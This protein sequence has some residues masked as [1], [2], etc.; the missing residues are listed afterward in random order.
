MRVVAYLR[1]S[2]DE[3]ASSGAGIEA[4]RA[5]ILAEAKRRGWQEAD[6]EFIEDLGFSAKNINRPGL[7]LALEALKRG[8]AKALVVA[9]MDRLS[10]SLLDFTQIMAEAQKQ[11][12]CL[13]ALDS[14]A[15]PSTPT[16]EAMISIL[17]TLA[18]WERRVIGLR[19]REALAI[20]RK[21]GVRLGR[22][23]TLPDQVRKRIKRERAKQRSL[24]AIA[25]ALN[26][27]RVPTAHGGARWHASTVRAVLA[28]S[29]SLS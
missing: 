20:K 28:G 29:R 1:V 17:A 25:A 18:Q 5:A 4:Q 23:R 10:R 9:K 11:G 15:D 16:G 13:I 19:T 3:Q 27:D 24:G 22:P 8:D 26:A 14:P 6:I 21:E 12:W 7:Q 2:S